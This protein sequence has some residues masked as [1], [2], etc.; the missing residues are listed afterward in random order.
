M[1]KHNWLKVLLLLATY[2]V[3]SDIEYKYEI[4][5]SHEIFEESN[6]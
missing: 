4:E 5:E 3:A 2:A 1:Y 6:K